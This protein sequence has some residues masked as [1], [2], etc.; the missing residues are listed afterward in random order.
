MSAKK[1]PLTLIIAFACLGLLLSLQFK[2]HQAM[3]DDLNYQS[4]ETLAAIA[5]NLTT[6]YYQLIQEIWD[7]KTQLKLLQQ[8]ADQNKAALEAMTREQQKLNIALG[9]ISVQGPG[10]TVTILENDQNY[11]GYQDMIDIINELWNS[12]AEAVSVNDF[13]ITNSVSIMPDSEFTAVLIN[14][15]RISY[16]YKIKAIG[17]PNSLEK[18]ISIPFGIVDNLRTLFK[19]PIIIEQE[20]TLRLPSASAPTFNYTQTVI[21][22]SISK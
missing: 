14:G 9:T 1:W 3:A 7:L 8:N 20:E 22:G 2:T 18:G 21:E 15:V 19:I 11:F 16:P 13:R 17:E 12:G 6:K 10:I 5:K 4:N